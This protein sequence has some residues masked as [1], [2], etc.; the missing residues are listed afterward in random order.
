[1]TVRP[2]FRVL[3]LATLLIGGCNVTIPADVELASQ[4]IPE[5]ISFSLHVRPILSDR[6]FSCH[7]PDAEG[8]VTDL[9]FDT[10]EGM[11]VALTESRR[12]RAVRGGNPGSSEL[13]HRILSHDPLTMMPPPESNLSLSAEEKA[14]LIR[15]IEQGAEYEDHWAF[16]APQRPDVPAVA[17]NA[18]PRDDVD[19]FVLARLEREGMTPNEPATRE[20]WIR[21]ASFDLTGLPPTPEEIDA[22]LADDSDKAFETVVDR[23]LASEHYGERMAVDWLDL[24]RYADSHG[25]QDDGWRNMWPWRD[26]VVRSFNANRPYD[27]FVVE[28]LAG[29][30]FENPT[31]EELLATGFNRNHLQSQEGGIVLEEFRVDYVANRTDTFGKAFLG[32][33]MECGRCHDHRYDPV[34]QDEYYE[35]FAFFNSVNEIGN[36]PYAGEA[37]PTVILTT[38]VEEAE[39]AKIRQKIAELEREADPSNPRWD[40]AAE[41]VQKG[42]PVTIQGMTAH[43]P[44]ESFVE[45][46]NLLTLEDRVQPDSA[47]YFWGDRERLP[48]IVDGIDGKAMTLVGDGW[49]DAGGKRHHFER[50][51]PFSLSIW[52][53]IEDESAW[54]P[55]IAKTGGLFDGDRGY[56][57]FLNPDHTLTARLV[58]VGPD[59]EIRIQTA[60]SVSTG[61]WNHLVFR[62]DGSSRAE[63]LQLVLDGEP[64]P[65]KV[66]TDNLRQSMRLSI[67]PFTGDSTN[68]AGNGDL[69]LGFTENNQHMLDQTTFDEWKVFDRWLTL[70]EIRTLARKDPGQDEWR[71]YAVSTGSQAWASVASELRSWRARENR[72]LTLAPEVMIMRDLPEPRP[73]YLLHRGEYDAPRQEVHHGTPKAVLAYPDSLPRN[74]LG[75]A[76]WLF[77]DENPLTARVQVNRL[78]QQVF[79][80]GIVATSD[81]F[82][83]QGAIPTHPELL[84][85]LALEYRDSGWDTKAMLRRLVLSATYRQSSVASEEQRERDPDNLLLARGPARRLTA[86]Q[87]RDH[88]LAASGL[89]VQEPGGPPVY[90]YQPAGLWKEQATRNGTEYTQS[91]GNDLYKRSLYTIWKR[92]TPPP[93]MMIFDTSERNLCI[94]RRQSTSTPLQALVVM[95]DPQYVEASR[96]LAE[97]MLRTAGDD[98]RRI[99]YGF[100]ALTARKPSEAE[101]DALL[102]LLR[103]QRAIFRSDPSAARA[104]LTTGEFPA[105][106]SLPAAEVAALTTVAST[107]MNHDATLILR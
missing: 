72:I 83:A 21:R 73:T 87:M 94:V 95:N 69:R 3:L 89:L 84:D 92:T 67:H 50:M 78:W 44:I 105:D 99:D 22:F 57:T 76:K 58:H 79:G 63:G 64:M 10:E 1:M 24:A 40:Q 53:R 59:N 86:E 70:P 39:L 88:A 8:R 34:S 11:R 52:F 17:D 80:R 41:R 5:D 19:R 54:G 32:L 12:S 38:E 81:N 56:H 37:S 100:Q 2:A 90:P 29:D 98:A 13:V 15:W 28:Q 31:Q 77:L 16:T 102:G 33:T 107:I 68:W 30:L 62:Y 7:G 61:D 106:G 101:R 47:G 75:L 25:Y 45:K 71:E 51:D 85:W 49:L 66:L 46:D 27:K 103:S 55:L 65:A 20:A 42:S 43:Y 9:R 96:L 4:R 23:L 26:W 18:W 82:G 104:L 14:I 91:H 97:R 6:C 35:L 74:R 60:D 48:T 93:S 36:I